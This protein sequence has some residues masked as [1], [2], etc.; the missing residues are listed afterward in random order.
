MRDRLSDSAY[1]AIYGSTDSEHIFGLL[2]HELEQNP[3]LSLTAALDQAL[4]GLVQL[5]DPKQVSFSA[6]MVISDGHQM[7]ASRL[8]H[9]TPTPTLYWLRD[10]PLF[11]DAVL[12]ASEPLFA[13]NWI[14]CPESSL[15]TVSSDLE[16]QISPF[17]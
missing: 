10:D 4:K 16:V 6:N 2:L 8:A 13:G 14:A 15:L 1:Q 12:I 9:R 3:S 7:V 5:A 17:S 11:P